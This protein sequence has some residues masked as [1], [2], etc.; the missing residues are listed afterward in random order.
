MVFD[1]WPRDTFY[2]P[3]KNLQILTHLKSNISALENNWVK[4]FGGFS[5]DH[6]RYLGISRPNIKNHLIIPLKKFELARVHYVIYPGSIN[7]ETTLCSAFKFGT[8]QCRSILAQKLL[9]LSV[10]FSKF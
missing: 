3:E 5:L 1:I 8:L 9:T 7:L 6:R 10:H 2:G 4:K